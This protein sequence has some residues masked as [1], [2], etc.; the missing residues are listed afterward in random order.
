MFYIRALSETEEDKY[1]YTFI[2]PFGTVTNFA[3]YCIYH[4]FQACH[5]V[6]IILFVH[7]M[8]ICY[9]NIHKQ[10]LM[11]ICLHQFLIVKLLFFKRRVTNIPKQ[12]VM[13]IFLQWVGIMKLQHLV[14][15]FVNII[16]LLRLIEIKSEKNIKICFRC[17]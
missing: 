4:V 2:F 9:I 12:C 17:S 16:N 11:F 13:F 1:A 10:C 6:K 5:I 3:R 7:E 8:C 15:Q 14:H